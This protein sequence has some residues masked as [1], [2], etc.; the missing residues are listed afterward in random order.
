MTHITTYSCYD[1]QVSSLHSAYKIPNKFPKC[2]YE[3]VL[4]IV[5]LPK[6]QEIKIILY[7]NFFVNFPNV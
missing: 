4:F 2:Y 1:K 3:I 5:E 6:L 7:L